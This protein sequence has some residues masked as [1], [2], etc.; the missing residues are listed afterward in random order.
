ML[1]SGSSNVVTG[2][3]DRLVGFLHPLNRVIMVTP[4]TPH[5]KDTY[6]LAMARPVRCRLI[7]GSIKL[8]MCGYSNAPASYIG[9]TFRAILS[10]GPSLIMNNVGRNSGS[11]MG[12]R[13]S[14]AVNIIVRKYLGKIPSVK[15]SLYGRRPGTSFRPTNPC[16]HRVTQLMLRGKLPPLAY[17][18][19]GFPS[20][21]R[22]GN[23]GVYRRAGKR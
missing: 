19:I 18:G 4:S 21:G 11:S 23:I 17:L 6:T 20:A 15:F 9:L 1:V 14:N 16:V 8:A 12:L 3:V 13:C 7:H 10:H 2:N 22:L 5:S